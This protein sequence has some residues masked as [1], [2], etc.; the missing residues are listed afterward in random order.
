MKTV[1]KIKITYVGLCLI[2]STLLSAQKAQTILGIAKENKPIEYYSEQ[3][4]LWKAEIKRDVNN[5]NAWHQYYKAKRAYLQLKHADVWADNQ[6]KIFE[7]LQPIIKDSHAHLGDSF[8]Y[9][10]MQAVNIRS[11][12]SIEYL[13]KAYALAPDRI[14][15][16]GWLFTHYSSHFQENQASEMAK[17]VLENNIYSNANLQWNNNALHTVEKNGI[18]IA[19]GDM[20]LLPKWI[21][22]YGLGIRKDVLAISKWK[23]GDDENYRNTIFTGLGISLPA[24]TEKDFDSKSSYN[25]FLAITLLKSSP[26]PGYM[27]CGTNIHLFRKHG[28]EEDMYLVGI[29]FRYSEDSFDNLKVTANNFEHKYN[30]NYLMSNFQIH[31]EDE[32]VKT[33]MNLTYLPGLMKLNEYYVNNGDSTKSN[34]YSAL[35]NRIAEESGRKEEVLSWFD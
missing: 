31:A 34:H 7:M 26:R 20:D 32:M 2:F 18:F 8:E 27:P 23:L 6:S 11:E 21:L 15:T 29:V 16:Y 17:L 19:N 9:Y 25:D 1:K 22:Q 4:A 33:R 14:E 35:I 10:F 13:E 24:K 12:K 28:I 3:S 5:G 30:L